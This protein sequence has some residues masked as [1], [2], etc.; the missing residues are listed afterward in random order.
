ML[1][2]HHKHSVLPCR[3]L[4]LRSVTGS[5]SNH[6]GLVGDCRGF[7]VNQR[8]EA[9]PLIQEVFAES[10][11]FCDKAVSKTSWKFDVVRVKFTCCGSSSCLRPS[12]SIVKYTTFTR[13]VAISGTAR[14][15]LLLQKPALSFADLTDSEDDRCGESTDF[16]L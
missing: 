16:L 13:R 12:I 10:Y 4:R 6:I 8:A 5:K 14:S 1:L 11:L 2:S 7:G 3:R 15:H 9:K